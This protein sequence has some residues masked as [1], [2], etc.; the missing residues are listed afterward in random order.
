M[1]QNEGDGEGD[2]NKKKSS[3]EDKWG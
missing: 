2:E 1:Y 3:K